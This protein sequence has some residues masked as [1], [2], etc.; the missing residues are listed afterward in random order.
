MIDL[1]NGIEKGKI[2]KETNTDFEHY[3]LH[4]HYSHL[5]RGTIII[6]ER[7]IFGYPHIK[8]IF[9]I[10]KGIER[11]FKSKL[12]FLEEKIDGFNLRIAN[13]SGNI[14]AF[15]RGGH[16][17]HFSTYKV[18]QISSISS[19]LSDNPQYVI[20]G[21]MIG[22]TPYTKPTKKFDVKLFVFD[23]MRE[24]GSLVSTQ[25]KYSI[26]D[27]YKI[28]SVPQLGSFRKSDIKKISKA[29]LSVHLRNGEGIVIRG[30]DGEIFKH[31]NANSDIN[32]I[33]ECASRY[34]DMPS[35]FFHQRVLR[36]TFFINEFK[37]N[38]G[39]L[40]SKLGSAFLTSLS[41]SV[42]AATKEKSSHEDFEILINEDSLW[43][44]IRHTMGNEILIE[45]TSR[46]KEG[47]NIRLRFRKI[48]RATSTLLH[49]YKNGKAVED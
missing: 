48:Y 30:S 43:Q 47:K 29:V 10:R 31:V 32:D 41:K 9:V 8:R 25:E 11:N 18:R 4:E 33:E 23:L 15:S 2:Q 28:D 6:G 37:L 12:L 42:L 45:E 19:F 7:M 44:K 21:E 46:K 24:D 17:D 1:K 36:A 3:Y 16:L 22:N 40:S 49:G 34:F 13:I 26:L 27:D 5:A 20:C 14:Y 38:K 39:K 35:G